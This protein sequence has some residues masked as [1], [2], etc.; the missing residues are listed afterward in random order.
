MKK[1][2]VLICVTIS[3]ALNAI[4]GTYFIN[5]LFREDSDV[6]DPAAIWFKMQIA[7]HLNHYTIVIRY[8]QTIECYSGDIRNR[9]NIRE[10]PYTFRLEEKKSKRIKPDDIYAITEFMS[11]L[12]GSS[13]RDNESLSD[14]SWVV[15]WIDFEGNAGDGYVY[16]TTH[17]YDE[18]INERIEELKKEIKKGKKNATDLS[19]ELYYLEI[20]R[21]FLNKMIELSPLPIDL[22]T[23]AKSIYPEYL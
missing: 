17:H 13:F 1:Y 16:A 23:P 8:N 14:A 19:S 3:V 7:H 6:F 2:I 9:K 21:E 4:L 11:K 20:Y 12:Y 18:Y 10:K 5:S 15:S 22:S